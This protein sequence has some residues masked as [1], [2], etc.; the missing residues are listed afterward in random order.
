MAR[1]RRVGADRPGM[2]ARERL[3]FEAGIKLGAIFHQYLGIPVSPT[4]AD[5]LARTI[6]AAVRL[7]P[8][9]TEARVRIV[10][11]RGA[12]VGRGRFGYRY[13]TPEMLGVQLTLVDRG[14]RVRA[15]LEYRRDLRYPLMSVVGARSG[16]SRRPT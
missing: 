14:E 3:L 10:P 11:S 4:T 8:F 1:R 9:V 7:Q 5:G 2:S 13:L 16:R 12:P 15:R 6:E